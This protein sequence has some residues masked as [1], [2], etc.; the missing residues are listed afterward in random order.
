MTVSVPTFVEKRKEQIVVKNLTS[1]DIELLKTKDPFMYYSI[2]AAR[3]AIMQGKNVVPSRLNVDAT[4]NSMASDKESSTQP[5]PKLS[6]VTRQCRIST[7]CH[8]DLLLEE[9]ICDPDLVAA[10][11]RSSELDDLDSCFLTL[12]QKMPH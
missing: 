1:S 6:N 5:A 3:N 11:S 10:M 12:L 7:E 4:S 9:I 2:P 8:P